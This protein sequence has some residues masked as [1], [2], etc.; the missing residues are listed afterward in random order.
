MDH[1][2]DDPGILSGPCALSSIGALPHSNEMVSQILQWLREPLALVTMGSGV[3]CAI[4]LVVWA[5]YRSI[6]RFQQFD[7]RTSGRLESIRN[8]ERKPLS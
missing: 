7:Q 2:N 8:Q 4:S 6:L 3:A 1:S 5:R